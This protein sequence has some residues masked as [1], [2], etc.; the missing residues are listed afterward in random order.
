M[1]SNYH[2]V[3]Y[4]SIAYVYL[5][6]YVRKI[7]SF[8]GLVI[9][10]RHFLLQIVYY[11]FWLLHPN[12]RENNIAI[13]ATKTKMFPGMCFVGCILQGILRTHVISNLLTFRLFRTFQNYLRGRQTQ[14]TKKFTKQNYR[15]LSS[16]EKS[17]ILV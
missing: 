16:L 17:V 6:V 13:V 3:F 1:H 4:A 9:V 14:L 15:Q 2:R 12:F 8:D 7:V 11:H 10:Y 5:I